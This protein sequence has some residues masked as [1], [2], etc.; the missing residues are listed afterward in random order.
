MWL[1]GQRHGQ[2][3]VPASLRDEAAQVGYGATLTYDGIHDYVGSTSL[4]SSV[5]ERLSGQSIEARRPGMTDDI[6]LYDRIVDVEMAAGL[7]Y[8]SGESFGDRIGS[9]FFDGVYAD[10]NRLGRDGLRCDDVQNLW[11]H[12]RPHQMRSGFHVAGLR[13]PV[14]GMVL[15]SRNRSMQNNIRKRAPG[16]AVWFEGL[17]PHG[18]IGR[19]PM[20]TR[21]WL[22]YRSPGGSHTW[23][24]ADSGERRWD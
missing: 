5:E 12:G 24:E 13:S 7:G 2:N 21:P 16:N 6:D 23:Q 1:A 14:L 9:E 18:S 4:D 3:H 19:A 15:D 17:G 11:R 22:D 20:P 8:R 10:Q